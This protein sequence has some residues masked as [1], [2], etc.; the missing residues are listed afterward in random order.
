MDMTHAGDE[1]PKGSCP[2]DLLTSQDLQHV[3]DNWRLTG[4]PPIPE[5][6]VSDSTYWPRFSTID[7]RLIYNITTLYTDMHRRGYSVCTVWAA[8][9]TK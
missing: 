8:K 6:R 9:M 7:L 5:L 2:P 3:L 4:E 1:P